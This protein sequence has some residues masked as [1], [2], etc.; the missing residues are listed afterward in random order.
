MLRR[1]STRVN[2]T[3]A[4]EAIYW[5]MVKELVHAV[6]ELREARHDEIR[7]RLGNLQEPSTPR[8]WATL[9]L[10]LA[11]VLGISTSVTGPLVAAMLYGVAEAG[12]DWKILR[13]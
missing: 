10:W 13:S 12:G 6:V 4:P 11:G 9:T 5:R 3:E 2:P 8:L 7:K 1:T